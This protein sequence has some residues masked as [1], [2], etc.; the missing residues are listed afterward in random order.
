MEVVRPAAAAGASHG[1]AQQQQQQDLA[2]GPLTTHTERDAYARHMRQLFSPPDMLAPDGGINQEF[3]RPRMVVTLADRK[4]GEA[5]RQLLYKG[6]A[7][8]GVGRCARVGGGGVSAHQ[9]HSS[10]DRG[11]HRRS[12]RGTATYRA[13][14]LQSQRLRR[15]PH[16]PGRSVVSI[17]THARAHRHH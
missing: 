6:L 14:D 8:L 11:A 12:S 5:E 15:A 4:W 16:P 17:A 2:Q 3:F 1:K 9:S 10:S 7:Q 13:C